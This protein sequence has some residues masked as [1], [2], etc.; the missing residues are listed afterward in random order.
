MGW[1]DGMGGVDEQVVWMD[2]WMD[3][4]MDGLIGRM[5]RRDGMHALD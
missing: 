2:G 4:W 5:H 1:T 3:A